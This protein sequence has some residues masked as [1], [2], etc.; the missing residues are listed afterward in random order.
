MR[1]TAAADAPSRASGPIL[2]VGCGR[3]LWR[4]ARDRARSAGRPGGCRPRRR[5]VRSPIASSR[6]ISRASSTAPV[7]S[8]R[9]SF[10][11]SSSTDWQPSTAGRTRSSTPIAV[12]AWERSK[13]PAGTSRT[14]SPSRSISMFTLA[15]PNPISA[16]TA[17]KAGPEPATAVPQGWRS[18]VRQSDARAATIRGMP[19]AIRGALAPHATVNAPDF[20][21][22]GFLG[23]GERTGLRSGSA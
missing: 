2:A 7:P 14:R 20:A 4:A 13:E 22:P 19:P 8:S 11:R 17:G 21:R 6:S 23:R 16:R 15:A 5:W 10:A 9:A 18:C 12:A 3:R 1:G